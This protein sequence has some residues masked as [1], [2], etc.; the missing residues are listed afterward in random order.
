MSVFVLDDKQKTKLSNLTVEQVAVRENVAIELIN[1]WKVLR[2]EQASD[3][4]QYEYDELLDEDDKV[5]EISLQEFKETAPT[6]YKR[7]GDT[8]GNKIHVAI[9]N[10][11]YTVGLTKEINVKNKIKEIKENPRLNPEKKRKQ[12]EER[13]IMLKEGQELAKKKVNLTKNLAWKIWFIEEGIRCKK[14]ISEEKFPKNKAKVEFLGEKFIKDVRK[15]M[16]ENGDD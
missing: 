3:N 12:I 16:Y 6:I 4:F 7:I 1:T 13:K 14:F 10:G 9:K 11:K 15:A 8:E 2:G 5:C